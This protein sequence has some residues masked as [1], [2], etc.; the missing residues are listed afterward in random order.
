[1]VGSRCVGGCLRMQCGRQQVCGGCLRMQCGRQQVCG[2]CL[3]SWYN[4][5]FLSHFLSELSQLDNEQLKAP[6]E[7]VTFILNSV[8]ILTSILKHCVCVCV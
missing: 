2:G 4:L 7:R 3:N 6:R 5:C 8:K 1:M